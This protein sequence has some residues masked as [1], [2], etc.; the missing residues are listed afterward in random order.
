MVH[1]YNVNSYPGKNLTCSDFQHDKDDWP[2]N[3]LFL[4][5]KKHGITVMPVTQLFYVIDF[6]S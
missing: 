3:K 4:V 5:K 6:T 2:Y 1:L